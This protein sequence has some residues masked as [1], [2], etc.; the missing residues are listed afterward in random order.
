VAETSV[1]IC[2]G[3]GR[4][5]QLWEDVVPRFEQAKALGT[6]LDCLLPRIM[7]GQLQSLA[8]EVMQV[9]ED[10]PGNCET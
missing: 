9:C 10:V 1:D 7:S 2:L 4:N 6:L 8:P 3:L 5:S